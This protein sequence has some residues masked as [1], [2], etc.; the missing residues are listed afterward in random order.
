MAIHGHH[1]IRARWEVAVHRPHPDA[2]RRRDVPHRRLDSRR[3][4]HCRGGI[5]QRL[6]VA[7][8]VSPLLPNWLLFPTVAGAHHVIPSHHSLTNGTMFR[9][10]G[11]GAVLRFISILW[12][13]TIM[14]PTSGN[15]TYTVMATIGLGNVQEA[16]NQLSAAA[17]TYRHVLQLLG[18]PPLPVVC[19]AHLG[20]AR[21][22]YEWNDLETA[23]QQ[24]QQ[25]LQLAGQ[26]EHA[27]RLV[28]SEVVLLTGLLV[29][30]A[31]LHG[32]IRKVRDLRIPLLSVV[33][34]KAGQAETS[35]TSQVTDGQ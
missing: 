29:D 2:S 24:A 17:E 4:E 26:L 18:E 21:I 6:F 19:E 5:K 13:K 33:C 32:L 1:Q 9:I 10:I 20:L 35:E 3:E 8:R 14:Q 30:Q 25:S 34:V 11:S 7:L 31:A 16:D 15:L 22:C 23:E 12:S 28:A 27:D